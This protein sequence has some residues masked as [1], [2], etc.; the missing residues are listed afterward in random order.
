MFLT[1]TTSLFAQHPTALASSNITSTSVDLSWDASICGGSVNLRYRI[2]GGVWNPNITG[3]T[4]PHLL[5]GLL[6]NTDYEWTV[7]CVGTGG[8][9]S[10]ELFTTAVVGPTIQM[11]LFHN[12]FC[13]MALEELLSLLEIQ[14]DMHKQLH[15]LYSCY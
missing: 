10:G 9:S 11:H 14:I 15:Q 7:K 13:V 2:V 8:W 3:V 4:S 6:A 12:L 5:S 1:I